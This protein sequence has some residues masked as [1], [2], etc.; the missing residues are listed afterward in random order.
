MEGLFQHTSHC[1]D[2]IQN[3]GALE[4]IGRIT[5]L[6]CLPYDFG[7]SFSSDSLVQVVRTMF[8]ALPNQTMGSLCE[9]VSVSLQ[10]SKNFWSARPTSSSKLL[11][12]LDI[13]AISDVEANQV[14]RMLVTLH[15]RVMLLSDVYATIGYA[16]NR[17]ALGLLQIF[18]GRGAPEVISDLGAL[19]R[20]L[21]WE[22]VL[23]KTIS[24]PNPPA[25]ELLMGTDVE[26]GQ[27]MDRLS[28]LVNNET[29]VPNDG[30]QDPG[31]ESV[32]SGPVAAGQENTENA[33]EKDKEEDV[34]QRA[35]RHLVTSI[36]NAL[37]PFFQCAS[38]LSR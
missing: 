11:T 6:S 19:H 18:I 8:D 15:V 30:T 5:A 24:P 29:Q 25:G 32:S 35:L 3:Y 13:N 10:D 38:S 33:R 28:T 26:S 4:Q 27:V 12:L 20:A 34:A 17:S 9:L 37:S 22:N 16:P 1:K 21:I 23:M 31:A 36:P 2:F 14:F 7:N